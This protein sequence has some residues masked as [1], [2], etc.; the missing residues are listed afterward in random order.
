MDRHATFSTGLYVSFLYVGLHVVGNGWISQILWYIS[1]I[2]RH[3]GFSFVIAWLAQTLLRKV[4]CGGQRITV[5]TIATAITSRSSF[6]EDLRFLVL[7]AGW[8]VPIRQ[9]DYKVI[10]DYAKYPE[11]MWLNKY[12]LIPPTVLALTAMALI[13]WVNGGSVH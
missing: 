11:L 12:H 1:R 6:D 2:V 8:L 13:G 9:T 7:H 3:A 10:G 4:H 5:I